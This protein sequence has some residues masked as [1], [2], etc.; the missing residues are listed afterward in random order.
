[1]RCQQLKPLVSRRLSDKHK[2]L[3]EAREAKKK[4]TKQKF[5]KMKKKWQQSEQLVRKI[6]HASQSPSNMDEKESEAEDVTIKLQDLKKN[7][8]DRLKRIKALETEIAKITSEL[9]KPV[10]TE[11]MEDINDDLVR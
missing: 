5:D 7:E 6:C 11:K 10:E 8:K 4:A 3:N 9:E 1:V 2:E